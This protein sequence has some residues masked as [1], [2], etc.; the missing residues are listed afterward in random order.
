[1]R[2]QEPACDRVYVPT[3]ASAAHV[4]QRELSLIF[5]IE[6]KLVAGRARDLRS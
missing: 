5:K 4:A 6:G 1:M 2:V 3:Y